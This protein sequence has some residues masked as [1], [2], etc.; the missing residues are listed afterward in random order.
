[1]EKSLHAELLT[2]RSWTLRGTVAA[3]LCPCARSWPHRGAAS[4]SDT[5]ACSPT[6]CAGVTI[7][8]PPGAH[9]CRLHADFEKRKGVR[10]VVRKSNAII[11]PHFRKINMNLSQQNWFLPK[12]SYNRP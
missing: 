12:H 3:G 6:P 9:D 1:M 2:Q 5:Q 8:L 11:K 10:R 4:R 7:P